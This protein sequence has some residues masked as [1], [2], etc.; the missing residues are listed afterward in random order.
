MKH[1]DQIEIKGLRI[2]SRVGVPDEER[3]NAQDLQVDLVIHP[4][5][6]LQAL[7]D[8]IDATI[9]YYQVSQRI[10]QV[11]QTGSRRLIETL[12]EEIAQAALKFERVARVEVEVKKFILTDTDYVSVKICVG[13]Y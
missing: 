5:E 13:D 1:R 12:A 10:H 7:A 6:S 11:A 2:Q 9:D 3:E 4:Q 8:D